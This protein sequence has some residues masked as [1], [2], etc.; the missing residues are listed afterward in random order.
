MKTKKL[1]I[2]VVQYEMQRLTQW[3]A[4]EDKIVR[5][6]EQVKDHQTD[7]LLLSEYAGLELAG[8][9]SQK[10]LP[11]QFSHIQT[12][13]EAYQQLFTFLA[14]Q[15]QLYIQPGTLPVREKNGAYR[16]RA[17]LFSP[18]GTVEYQDK[19]HLTPFENNTGLLKSG[20]ELKVFST[21]LGKLAITTCYDCEFPLVVKSLCAQGT[22]IILVPS[23]TEKISGLTRVSIS[24]QARA[25]E[26]QCYV[27]QSCLVG[28]ASWNDFIDINAGQSAVY[29]PADM[30]FPENGVLV[31]APLNAPIII[32]ADLELEKLEH[33]RHNGEMRNYKD[34]QQDVN[35]LIQSI[36][37]ID[38]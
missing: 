30:G 17:Y 10:Q 4:F 36:T 31:E 18:Q 1:K 34:M 16:N 11:E 38:F 21:S 29:C 20:E 23:C 32:Y 5:L 3:Q 14:K 22:Q 25:I 9:S 6:V 15:Y 27:A 33:V 2:A 28:K 8:W 37:N 13:L 26:N 19:I 12:Q 24:A 7:L 35:T